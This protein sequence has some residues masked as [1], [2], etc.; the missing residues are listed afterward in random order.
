MLININIL[1]LNSHFTFLFL[2]EVPNAWLNYDKIYSLDNM[3]A[4]GFFAT[5]FKKTKLIFLR[6]HIFTFQE[7]IK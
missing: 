2:Y 4:S 1:H 5:E 6:D 3:M 7:Y